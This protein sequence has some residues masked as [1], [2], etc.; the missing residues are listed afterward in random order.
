[1]RSWPRFPR[2]DEARLTRKNAKFGRYF[3]AVFRLKPPHGEDDTIT[4][5]WTREGKYWK[6]ISWDLETPGSKPAPAP[7]T[8]PQLKAVAEERISGDAGF[9]QASH[10]FLS[11]WLVKDNFDLA[12]SYFSPQAYGCVGSYLPMNSP[13]PKTPAES[14]AYLRQ[15]LTTIAKDVGTV[16]HLHDATEPMEPDHDD[17]KLV[18]HADQDAYTA[19]AVPESLLPSFT[20]EKQMSPPREDPATAES[21][22]KDYG[23]YYA[24]LFALKTPGDHPAALTLLWSKVDGQWK[25]VSYAIVTP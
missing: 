23:K 25:V 18:A 5:L 12:A 3:G 14:V 8:R 19:V 20:C 21:A 13:E 24:V 1:M 9:L 22:P 17:L 4:T 6:V 15:S 2:Y 16:H 7:D 10:K 11:A